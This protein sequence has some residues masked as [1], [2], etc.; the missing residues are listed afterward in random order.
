MIQKI[1]KEFKFK[2]CVFKQL[3]RNGD[4]ALYEQIIDDDVSRFE[5]IIIKVCDERE[6]MGRKYPKMEVYPTK[7]QWGSLAL[8]YLTYK[9][10]YIAYEDLVNFRKS[11][12]KPDFNNYY[13]IDKNKTKYLTEKRTS[14]G[15]FIAYEILLKRDKT[16][17]GSYIDKNIALSVFRNSA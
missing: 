5:L 8:T 12:R 1:A 15:L 7:E 13:I 16:L 14:M 2:G 9:D 3:K 11:K 4:V 6:I 17:I 10:A